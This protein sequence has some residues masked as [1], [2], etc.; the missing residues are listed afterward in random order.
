M[1]FLVDPRE[2]V[3][4]MVTKVTTL[5]HFTNTYEGAR[6]DDIVLC[7]GIFNVL[8]AIMIKYL[9]SLGWWLGG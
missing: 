6:T 9:T 1:S 5:R 8:P 2:K 4:G 7:G 3:R